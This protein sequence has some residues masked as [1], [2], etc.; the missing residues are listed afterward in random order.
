MIHLDKDPTLRTLL[1]QEALHARGLYPGEPDN[2][3]GPATSA[4]LA[5]FQ[6]SFTASA[7]QSFADLVATWKLRH[8]TA[9]ELLTKGGA[10]AR[11]GLNTDPPPGL[12]KNIRDAASAADEARQRLGSP[13][14][15]T[16]AYRSPAYNKAIGGASGSFH[17]HFRALDIIPARASVNAL[18]AI[19]RQLRRE[20]HPGCRGIG[21][22][23]TFI[24]ID[25]GPA[26]DF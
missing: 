12:W 3:P 15:I 5:T 17:L 13:L 2:W 8:F 26:R 10:H 23:S 25:N 6:R 4:A 19:F 7:S 24:H 14:T 21:K 11:N 20:G 16:S 18:H 1:I 9:A 22:Y